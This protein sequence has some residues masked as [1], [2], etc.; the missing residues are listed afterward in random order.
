MS[1][2]IVINL[3]RVGAFDGLGIRRE[4]LLVQVPLVHAQ[5]MGM[6]G[7]PSGRAAGGAGRPVAASWGRRA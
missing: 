2:E 6:K 3:V 4:E 7:A 5:V 1:V